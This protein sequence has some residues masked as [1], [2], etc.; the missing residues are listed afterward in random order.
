M[1]YPE[2]WFS[3]AA[4]VKWAK[5]LWH[6]HYELGVKVSLVATQ[7]NNFLVGTPETV[8]ITKLIFVSFVKTSSGLSI[9]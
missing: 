5:P 4:H 1:I 8:Q 2:K 7:K 9:I 6:K 3:L